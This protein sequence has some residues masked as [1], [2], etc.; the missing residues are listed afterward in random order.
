MFGPIG[1][2]VQGRSNHPFAKLDNQA[3]IFGH[4]NEDIR[5]DHAFFFMIPA[6]QCFVADNLVGLD[7]DQRL[8]EQLQLVALQG[9]AK[10]QFDIAPFLHRFVHRRFEQR[11]A[12]AP[13]FLG[14]IEG[15]IGI[16]DQLFASVAAFGGNGHTDADAG[17]D[18][19]SVDHHR[20][21]GV[22]Y[23]LFRNPDDIL[24]RTTV[25]QGYGKFIATEAGDH[26]LDADG[27]FKAVGDRFENHVAG[28]V[29]QCI[30][31]CLEIIEVE[32]EDRKPLIVAHAGQ[33]TLQ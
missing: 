8:V 15:D 26:S 31:D 3:G 16:F 27:A 17:G 6:E 2:F 20:F 11:N 9:L 21:R 4:R 12:A 32:I 24:V 1:G 7:I 29:T 28:T 23:N 14:M 10:V 13:V 19:L 30:V 18:A 33:R 22:L 25:A 5:H